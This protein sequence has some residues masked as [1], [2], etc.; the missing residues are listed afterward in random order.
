M[1]D[2]RTELRAFA[3]G[4]PETTEEFP[5]GDRVA[6]VRGKIFVF[7]GDAP[8]DTGTIA[9]KLDE[10]HDHAL[11]ID[12]AAPTGYG[13]GKAGWVTVPVVELPVDVLRDWIEESYRLVA[14]KRI[15]AAMDVRDD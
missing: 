12:G 4:L 8:V 3:L 9:I 13:L 15:V 5:W 7:L 14:P 11:S 2:L 1:A 10:A 6:K